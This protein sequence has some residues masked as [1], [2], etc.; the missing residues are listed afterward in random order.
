MDE[1]TEE[2]LTQAKGHEQKLLTNLKAHGLSMTAPLL[3]NIASR[4]I[5]TGF[6]GCKNQVRISG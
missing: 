5:L 3:L 1:Y 2:H 6:H 4:R